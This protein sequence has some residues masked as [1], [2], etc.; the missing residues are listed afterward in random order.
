LFDPTA[1]ENMKV[2]LEGAVYDM[3]FSGEIFVTDRRDLVNLSN[4]SRQF[5]IEAELL[6]NTAKKNIK[7]RI[8][9]EASL[10]NLAAE[11]LAKE[12]KISHSKAGCLIS[13][14]FRI[15]DRINE[16]EA[17]SIIEAMETIWGDKR[18]ISVSSQSSISNQNVEKSE[19]TQVTVSFGRLITEDQMDD[20]VQI[21]ET[22]SQSLR[23]L[24][25]QN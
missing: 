17:K 24:G 18:E 1:F 15:P 13:I 14:T 2:V 23:T 25:N 3:D 7:A 20:I 9:L 22:M 11:L 12:P 5:E 10:E 6:P 8:V 19:S 4:L 21:A 16:Q